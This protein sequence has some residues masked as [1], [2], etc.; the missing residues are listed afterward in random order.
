MMM[1]AKLAVPAPDPLPRFVTVAEF[2]DRFRL[3]KSFAYELL[4]AGKI[5][6]VRIGGARRI[7]VAAML[8]FADLLSGGDI[9]T[10]N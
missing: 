7:P 6:S 9:G 1:N 5:R 4:S 2:C 10:G 3:S 8:E